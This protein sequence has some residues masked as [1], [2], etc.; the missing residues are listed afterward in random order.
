MKQLGKTLV[1]VLLVVSGVLAANRALALPSDCVSENGCR[2]CYVR[3]SDGSSICGWIAM[4][5]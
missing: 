3:C 1:S 4:C 2:I 5:R